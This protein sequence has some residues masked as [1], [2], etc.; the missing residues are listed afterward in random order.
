MENG[1]NKIHSAVQHRINFSTLAFIIIFLSGCGGGGSSSDE[2]AETNT[3]TNTACSATVPAA[4][5]CADITTPDLTCNETRQY[6]SA[7]SLNNVISQAPTAGTSV[8]CDSAVALIISDGPAPVAQSYT[9][10]TQ[11]NSGGSINPTNATVTDGDATNFTVTAQTGYSIGNVSGCSGSLTGSTYTT[12]T[13]SANCSVAV[14][15]TAD[16]KPSTTSFSYNSKYIFHVGGTY[17][18]GVRDVAFTNDGGLVITGGSFV[19]PANGTHDIAPQGATTNV[20]KNNNCATSSGGDDMDAFVMRFDSAGNLQWIT[21]IGGP[22]YER[23]YAIE[24]AS[25]GD[26]VIAGR[27]GPCTYTTTGAFQETFSGDSAENAYGKQ[28]GFVTR[29]KSDGTLRW[30]TF[31][32]GN[33]NA[34]IR[35]MDLDSQDNVVIG[36]FGTGNAVFNQWPGNN[37]TAWSANAFLTGAFQS[38]YVGGAEDSLV[39]KLSSDGTSL[40]WASRMGGTNRDGSQPSI[41]IDT[42]DDIVFLTHGNSNNFNAN[43]GANEIKGAYPVNASPSTANHGNLVKLT[44]DGY[45]IF[46]RYLGGNGHLNGDTHNLWVDK[47][48]LIY[49]GD[50]LCGD[51]GACYNG[52]STNNDPPRVLSG[53]DPAPTGLQTSYAGGGILNGNWI[54]GNYPGDAYI[55][56]LSSDGETVLASTFF[57]GRYGEGLEGIAVTDNGNVVI[58]GGTLSQDLPAPAAGAVDSFH[59]N[60][61]G[62]VAVLSSDLSEVLHLRYLGNN[63]DADGVSIV[64]DGNKIAMVGATG[65]TATLHKSPDGYA[66]AQAAPLAGLSSSELLPNIGVLGGVDAWVYAFDEVKVTVP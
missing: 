30:S 12:G 35:D 55:V 52:K 2:P 17:L 49:T 51:G 13:I 44:K 38:T 9:V 37:G 24:T 23:S 8:A 48:N 25:N 29:L 18:D 43:A 4:A 54:T 3:P 41:R 66:T 63:Q 19:V 64:T 36:T 45:H 20:Y 47:N 39:A 50:S 56:K 26:F 61:D 16:S 11:I 62:F 42:N 10:S 15:F 32:G 33:D 1:N 22:Y 60:L 59:G 57:G 7:V 40:L 27:A 21:F 53:M 34:F 28:D 5:S 6:S 46:T 31:L 58:S 14:T 65:Q